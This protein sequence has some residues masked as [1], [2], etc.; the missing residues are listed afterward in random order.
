MKYKISTLFAL[1]VIAALGANSYRQYLEL[2]SL[3]EKHA[4][5]QVE[6]DRIKKDG[7]WL[8]SY[9][10]SHQDKLLRL[11]DGLDSRRRLI[12]S[13]STLNNDTQER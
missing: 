11:A 5:L 1:L 2:R 10:A 9:Y 13:R 3:Q 4:E 7:K 12:L 8:A 6:R